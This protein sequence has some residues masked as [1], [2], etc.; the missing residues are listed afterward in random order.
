MSPADAEIL[1]DMWKMKRKREILGWIS[2]VGGSCAEE[3]K[4][5]LLTLGAKSEAVVV[6]EVVM[7]G[8]SQ[9]LRQK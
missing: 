8:K 4:E 1:E 5:E 7:R 2:C 3:A 6:A 9:Y